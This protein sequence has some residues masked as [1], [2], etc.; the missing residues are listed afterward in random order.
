ESDNPKPIL[1]WNASSDD[2]GDALFYQVELSQSSDFISQHQFYGVNN[3]TK[4]Y[5]DRVTI[6]AEHF[7]DKPGIRINGL[8]LL[9][10]SL[11]NG[12]FGKGLLIENGSAYYET[13]GLI[14]NEGSIE[15]WFKPQASYADN[16]LHYLLYAANFSLLRS[17]E[18]LL[19]FSIGS[20][21]VSYDAASWS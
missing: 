21:T 18:G 19:N 6:L 1:V 15:F 13:A 11:V 9:N 4:P 17:P 10:A 2:D 12:R 5:A 14:S 16:S 7:D 3:G 8:L 20:S